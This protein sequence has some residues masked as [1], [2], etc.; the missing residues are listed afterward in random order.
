M[1]TGNDRDGKVGILIDVETLPIGADIVG[2]TTLVGLKDGMR[3]DVE[4]LTVGRGSEGSARVDVGIGT[5]IESEILAD[6]RTALVGTIDGNISVALTDGTIIVR[7]T[8]R[9]GSATLVGEMVG[10]TIV[11]ETLSVGR[12]M[13]VGAIDGNPS[14]ALAGGMMI[15]REILTDGGTRFVG[16]IGGTT[17]DEMFRVGMG[18]EM[19]GNGVSEGSVIMVEMFRVGIGI[20]IGGND[21]SEGRV[22]A[23]EIFNDGATIGSPVDR[24]GIPGADAFNKGIGI[25]TDAVGQGK[26]EDGS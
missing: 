13:L 5:T 25:E 20:E 4:M 6:G 17:I 7:V 23:V 22:I 9:D 11:R 8:L 3:T 10:T 24:E 2:S 19:G 1:T 16:T 14:V 26:A 12:M 18:T 15:E 21:V